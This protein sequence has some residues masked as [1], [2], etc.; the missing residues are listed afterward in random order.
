MSTKAAPQM[1]PA[2]LDEIL[3]WDVAPIQVDHKTDLVKV[4]VLDIEPQPMLPA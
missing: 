3:D 4:K 2:H 1:Y